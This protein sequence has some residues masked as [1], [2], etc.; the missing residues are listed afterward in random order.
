GRE[1]FFMP[2]KPPFSLPDKDPTL[3]F[4]QPLRDEVHHFAITSHRVQRSKAI[5]RSPLDEIPGIGAK[6]KKAL[7]NRFGSAK[8]VGQG[9]LSDLQSVEGISRT[10]A[11]IIYNFFHEE[12]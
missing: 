7:L 6:R 4:L 8:D 2:G 1:R 11:E 3:Y 12:S 5:G 10:T 9:A